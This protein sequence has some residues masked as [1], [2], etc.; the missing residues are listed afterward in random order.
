VIQGEGIRHTVGSD[1]TWSQL[2][3]QLN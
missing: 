1:Q 3:Q 2:K